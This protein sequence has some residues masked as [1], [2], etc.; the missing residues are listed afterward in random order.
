MQEILLSYRLLFGQEKDSRRLYHSMKVFS[1]AEK[2]VCDDLLNVLCGRA[3]PDADTVPADQEGYRLSRD[4]PI[5]RARLAIL[6]QQLGHVKPRG[7]RT[8]WKDR[9]DTV[10]WYTF[11]AVIFFGGMGV[12]LSTL[13]VILQAIQTFKGI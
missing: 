3:K 12:I 10:Q 4:F 5:L 2:D 11:W 7:W 9:R 6:Q 1:A 8:V 13:Q